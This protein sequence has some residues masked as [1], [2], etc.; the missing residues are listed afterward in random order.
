M[1]DLDGG[2]R[3]AHRPEQVAAVPATSHPGLDGLVDLQQI[4][5][6][7]RPIA[8]HEMHSDQHLHA[9]TLQPTQPLL[10]L[11]HVLRDIDLYDLRRHPV[12]VRRHV[13]VVLIPPL[14][15]SYAEVAADR[16]D[17]LARGAW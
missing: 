3:G 13:L 14:Q 7:G 6:S 2:G 11:D 16:G 4:G 15:L 12:E 5:Y 9:G 10:D 17:A 1:R 8:L